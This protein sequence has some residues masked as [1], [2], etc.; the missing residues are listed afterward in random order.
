MLAKHLANLEEMTKML[1][2]SNAPCSFVHY[3]VI[4]GII[5][6]LIGDDSMNAVLGR[7]REIQT[8][9]IQNELNVARGR[10]RSAFQP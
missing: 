6:K 9:Q 1:L 4:Q 8:R 10:F 2:L 7:L 5:K 3:K